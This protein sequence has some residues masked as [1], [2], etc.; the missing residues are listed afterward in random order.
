MS[1]QKSTPAGFPES[2][3][4]GKGTDG[5]GSPG[6]VQEKNLEGELAKPAAF[7]F[8]GSETDGRGSPGILGEGIRE[9]R[10]GETGTTR[11]GMEGSDTDGP[12]SGGILDEPPVEDE[13]DERPL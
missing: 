5:R 13:E 6:I 12:G 11:F 1:E 9:A 8:E 3:S 4:E 2:E 7:D 10:A